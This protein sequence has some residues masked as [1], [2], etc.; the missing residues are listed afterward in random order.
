MQIP[1]Q[2]KDNS[3]LKFR[4]RGV[5]GLDNLLNSFRN[6]ISKGTTKIY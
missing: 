5:V 3:V 6:Q 4:S 1:L 2:K